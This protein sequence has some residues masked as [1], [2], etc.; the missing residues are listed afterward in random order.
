MREAHF[1]RSVLSSESS[2]LSRLV[3]LLLRNNATSVCASDFLQCLFTY[4]QTL[5]IHGHPTNRAEDLVHFIE[6]GQIKLSDLPHALY[7]L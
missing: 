2:A 1:G 4:S 6:V 7:S 3:I 5:E